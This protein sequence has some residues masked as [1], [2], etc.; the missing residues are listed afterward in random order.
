[1]RES[2]G[3]IVVMLGLMLTLSMGISVGKEGYESEVRKV[4]VV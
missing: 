1:M 3:A 2:L 4:G